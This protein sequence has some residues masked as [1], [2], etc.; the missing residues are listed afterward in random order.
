MD[1]TFQGQETTKQLVDV[2]RRKHKKVHRNLLK[3]HYLQIMS[4]VMMMAAPGDSKAEVPVL[5]QEG[6][7]F[8][9]GWQSLKS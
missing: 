4:A 3:R 8:G 9:Q 7:T 2:G 6:E 5:G 1:R